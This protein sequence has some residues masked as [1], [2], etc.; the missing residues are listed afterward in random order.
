LRKIGVAEVVALR[1]GLNG[2]AEASLPVEK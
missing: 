2:W 1:G